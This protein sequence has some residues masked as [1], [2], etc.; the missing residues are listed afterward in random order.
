M[1][2]IG[3]DL[4]LGFVI[5]LSLGLLG[6]GGSIL[7]GDGLIYIVDGQSGEFYIIEPSPEGFK[8]QGK[9]KLLQGQQIWGPLALS[10]GKLLIRD[11]SQIK[12]LDVKA[13]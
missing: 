2:S 9:A 5:G 10:D 12:C 4:L 6:G 7:T 11:Q 3:L 1:A 13:N 8:S